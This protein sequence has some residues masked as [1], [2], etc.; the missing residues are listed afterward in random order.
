MPSAPTSHSGMAAALT[1]VSLGIAAIWFNTSASA[2][3]NDPYQNCIDNHSMEFAWARCGEDEIARQEKRLASAWQKSLKCFDEND[4]DEKEGK[5]E[6]IK[7][8]RRWESWKDNS[9]LVYET[10][11][12]GAMIPV[13]G[14]TCKIDIIEARIKFLQDIADPKGEICAPKPPRSK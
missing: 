9:C 3:S 13:I 7:D 1:I 8:Q 12:Y 10:E 11:H 5:R 2:A 6:L 4:A 14:K